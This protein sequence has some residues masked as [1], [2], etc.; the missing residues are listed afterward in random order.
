[1]MLFPL[2]WSQLLQCPKLPCWVNCCILASSSVPCS[3]VEW[4]LS[5]LGVVP[6]P[7]GPDILLLAICAHRVMGKLL[8]DKARHF[9]VIKASL[10]P[11]IPQWS[12][13]SDVS[14]RVLLHP[15]AG[16]SLCW[17]LLQSAGGRPQHELCLFQH[18]SGMLWWFYFAF[19][20][21]TQFPVIAIIGGFWAV[22]M[23]LI[24]VLPQQ[25]KYFRVKGSVLTVL[26][27]STTL[28]L[29]TV[30]DFTVL[31]IFLGKWFLLGKFDSSGH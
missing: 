29:Y 4:G 26:R 20:K 5:W 11:C 16:W 9:I 21:I 23:F 10:A 27:C 14:E 24:I 12:R 18:C 30:R 28:A 6:R 2:Q 22:F 1:M 19:V 3:T 25:Y 31:Y 17:I 8:S 13:Y 15:S 7:V